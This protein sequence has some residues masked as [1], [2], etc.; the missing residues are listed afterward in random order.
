MYTQAIYMNLKWRFAFKQFY[1]FDAIFWTDY[2]K[3][4]MLS[5]NITLMV[6]TE[7]ISDLK[8]YETLN[9]KFLKIPFTKGDNWFDKNDY[10]ILI[11]MPIS[12]ASLPLT[13]TEFN[14]AAQLLSTQNSAVYSSYLKSKYQDI[15]ANVKIQLFL[16]K[17]TV[18]TDI[19]KLNDILTSLGMIDAFDPSLA[20]FEQ[21][22]H[23][24]SNT[25]NLYLS[26]IYHQTFFAMNEEGVEAA[27]ATAAFVTSKGLP[28]GPI[29]L[30]PFRVDHPFYFSILGEETVYQQ[31][32]RYNV[33][34]MLF[35][36]KVNCI[37]QL[38]CREIE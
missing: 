30:I 19:Y 36:G 3:S 35:L 7:S 16:P 17:M 29:K 6:L 38:K 14:Q 8:L 2:R 20:N 15:A 4:G 22:K 32:S 34:K 27:A 23:P 5:K 25:A 9:F 28:P 13:Y 11:A 12:N 33:Q 1:N 37:G 18:K 26:A 21:L 31:R 24:N 10:S